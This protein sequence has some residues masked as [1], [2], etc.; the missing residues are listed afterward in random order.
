[1]RFDRAIA[2][3]VYD[4]LMRQ[5]VLAA[6]HATGEAAAVGLACLMADAAARQ[7]DEKLDGHKVDV[8]VSIPM[9][10]RR[11]IVRQH[12]PTETM[13]AVVAKRLSAPFESRLLAWRRAT[14][15]QAELAITPRSQNVRGAMR[16]RSGYRFPSATIVVV[17]DIL[18]T[19]AT[20][21]DAA[22]ALKEAGAARVVAVVAARSL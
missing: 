1:M 22:R 18:T 6:K 5:Q 3:G 11:R 21:S 14:R 10:W 9:H 16:A 8:V 2:A 13:G 20:C 12:N 19:G 17:D 7:L 15:K 4:G